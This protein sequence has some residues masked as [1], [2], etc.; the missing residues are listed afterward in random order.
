MKHAERTED[1]ASQGKL[2]VVQQDDGSMVI[3]I[4]TGKPFTADFAAVSLEFGAD[5]VGSNHTRQALRKL[6]AAMIKDETNAPL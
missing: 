1:A 3:C 5:A 2:R 4:I 6:I